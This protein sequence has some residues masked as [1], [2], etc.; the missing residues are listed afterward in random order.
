MGQAQAIDPKTPAKCHS[1][2]AVSD[3]DAVVRSIGT[4]TLTALFAAIGMNVV[5]FF[6]AAIF[7][8]RQ[9]ELTETIRTK[10]NELDAE[11]EQI[12]ADRVNDSGELIRINESLG[13]IKEQLGRIE[14]KA[15]G[16]AEHDARVRVLEM[17][18]RQINPF[19]PVNKG[20]QK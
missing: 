20:N 5:L 10:V 16:L 2:V 6:T 1:A 18:M 11:M 8:G 9:I 7:V 13:G 17:Q 4:K 3:G 19:H 12:K 14:V 15:E